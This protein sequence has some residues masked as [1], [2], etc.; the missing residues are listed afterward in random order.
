MSKKSKSSPRKTRPDIN[1]V[2]TEIRNLSQKYNYDEQVLLSFAEFVNG[3]AFKP[4]E[5]SMQDLKEAVIAAFDCSSYPELKKNGLFKLF[6]EEHQLKMNS[7][8]SWLKVYRK[9]VGL[10]DSERHSIGDTSINGVDV[11]RNFLP[12]EVFQLNPKTATSED[13]KSAFNQLAKEHHPDHGGNPDVFE[14]LKSMRDSL[15]A[16]Y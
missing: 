9:F 11:L 6:V 10:P 16:A 7:K 1:K 2:R 13:V 14:K 15:L 3:G 8:T 12:W 5:P 4:V